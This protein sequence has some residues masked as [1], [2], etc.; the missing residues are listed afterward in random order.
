[1]LTERCV[2]SVLESEMVKRIRGSKRGERKRRPK[3]FHCK[4]L[5][6]G[7]GSSVGI[8]TDYGLAV[9][10]SN[11]GGGEIFRTCPDWLWGPPSLLYSGYRVFPGSKVRS[12]RDADHSPP[13]CAEV[14][15]PPSGPHR[16]CNGVTL[17]LP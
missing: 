10:G 7:P 17:P 16:V 12:E 1:M 14:I 8:A 4:R 13:S 3:K 11:P 9:R 2:L 15:Y 5:T 6:S